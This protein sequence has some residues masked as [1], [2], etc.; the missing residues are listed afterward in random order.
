MA[1]SNIDC[2]TLVLSMRNRKVQ[3]EAW[4]AGLRQYL[5]GICSSSPCPIT[6][7]AAISY[8][9]EM[10]KLRLI[11]RAISILNKRVPSTSSSSS[12]SSED[13]GSSVP[14]EDPSSL[15]CIQRRYLLRSMELSI[16]KSQQAFEYVKCA[17]REEVTPS[18]RSPI[19]RDAK[20][21]PQ[22]DPYFHDLLMQWYKEKAI[23]GAETLFAQWNDP[24]IHSPE[25][26]GTINPQTRVKLVSSKPTAVPSNRVS[27]AAAPSMAPVAEET[28]EEYE[29]MRASMR[30]PPVLSDDESGSDKA[31]S[32]DEFGTDDEHDLSF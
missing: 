32:G 15:S 21:V 26:L 31:A 12:S 4:E 16:H 13:E 24:V 18:S 23:D 2:K 17:V 22:P 14:Q 28:A 19:S 29:K 7:E 6:M 8:Q 11:G 5:D 25:I 1:T 20:G 10:R 27:S 30:S 9:F 3:L